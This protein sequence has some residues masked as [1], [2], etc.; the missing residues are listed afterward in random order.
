MSYFQNLSKENIKCKLDQK[1][2]VY[3][4]DEVSSTN[5]IAKELP[6]GSVVFAKRQLSGRGREGR[7]FFSG[8]GGLYMSLCMGIKGGAVLLGSA[9]APFSSGRVTISAGAAVAKTLIGYGA[10]ARIKWVNDIYVGG[11]KVC[12]IL[13]ERTGDKVILGIGVNVRSQIPAELAFKAA[14]LDLDVDLSEMGAKII[15]EFSREL[16]CPDIEF[17]N[18]KCLTLG[19]TVRTRY[20]TG[21]AKAVDVDG[22]LIAETDGTLRRLYTGEAEIVN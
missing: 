14:S 2:E 20:G 22:A 10:D 3:V 19:K 1:L 6:Y 4:F 17:V 13:A 21:K 15:N 9:S 11:K 12:G 5:D 8:D 7:S 18:E 16:V